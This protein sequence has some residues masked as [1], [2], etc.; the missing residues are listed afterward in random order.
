LVEV[1]PH[2]DHGQRVK[3]APSPGLISLTG[4]RSVLISPSMIASR[5]QEMMLFVQR[6]TYGNGSRDGCESWD[7]S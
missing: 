4:H 5:R 1:L 7:W 3:A 2:L 6:I